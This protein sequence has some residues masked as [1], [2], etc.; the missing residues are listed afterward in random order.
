MV[1]IIIM[2]MWDNFKSKFYLYFLYYLVKILDIVFWRKKN[3]FLLYGVI[4]FIDV[5]LENFINFFVGIFF[6]KENLKM[7]NFIFM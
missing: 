2:E 4:R 6:L 3:Y 7:N 5:F 1:D